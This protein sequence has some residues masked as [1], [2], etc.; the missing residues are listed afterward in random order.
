V[1]FR[2]DGKDSCKCTA[3]AK[4][5]KNSN[6]TT[7]SQ[8]GHLLIRAVLIHVAFWRC[9]YVAAEIIMHNDNHHKITSEISSGRRDPL[10]GT[11][12]RSDGD[13]AGW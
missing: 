13:S 11:T 5:Y 8:F 3:P 1:H 12:R 6:T 9:N 4:P 10:S 7:A 2:D